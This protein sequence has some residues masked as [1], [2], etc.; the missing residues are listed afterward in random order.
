MTCRRI[1]REL[2][3][4]ARFGEFGP[5]SQPHLDH[6]AGCA[7]CRDEV[8]YDRAMVQQLRVALAERIEGMTP[9]PDVWQRILHRAQAAEPAPTRMWSWSTAILARLRT[10]SAVTATGLALVLALNMEVVPV[11]M[12]SASERQAAPA[13]SR[14]E[15]ASH[16]VSERPPLDFRSPEGATTES[17]TRDPEGLMSH[18]DASRVVSRQAAVLHKPTEEAIVT[19]IR[20]SFRNLAAAEAA[21][22]D[23]APVATEV[24]IDLVPL[25]P[26]VGEP[27]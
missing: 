12:P 3:W 17:I 11:A 4:L 19:Q 26:E 8:G 22:P 9:S 14:V 6:L 10:V 7:S 23:E 21:G 25:V 2:L 24:P 13:V 16:I 18:V 27:S 5:S 15:Q 20:V 1:C